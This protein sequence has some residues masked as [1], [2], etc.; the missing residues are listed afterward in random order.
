MKE[1]EFYVKYNTIDID[2]TD[3][4]NL[5]KILEKILGCEHLL[6]IDGIEPSKRKGYHIKM[7]CGQ[8]C[9]MCRLLFDDS[10]R[11]AFDQFRPI[12]LQNVLHQE[13][14]QILIKLTNMEES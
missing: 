11:F 4:D 12:S 8:D 13:T 14:E 3:K 10:T 9:V 5:I 6:K 1:M 2:S 7:F